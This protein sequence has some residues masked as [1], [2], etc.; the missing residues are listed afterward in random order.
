MVDAS[1][2]L[3]G[4][5]AGGG[6]CALKDC[7]QRGNGTLVADL[8]KGVGCP[9]N[10]PRVWVLKAFDQRRYSG[11]PSRFPKR[12]SCIDAQITGRMLQQLHQPVACLVDRLVS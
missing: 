8:A 3:R 1:E 10:N 5:D 12:H 2:R 4:I 9:R 6:I 11:P 7:G